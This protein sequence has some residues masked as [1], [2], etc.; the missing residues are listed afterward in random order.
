M[1]PRSLESNRFPMGLR[2]HTI[3]R[4]GTNPYGEDLSRNFSP[5]ELDHDDES[6]GRTV[7]LFFDKTGMN[8]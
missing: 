4:D 6:T 1:V 5:E 2:C 7:E 3:R 8:G